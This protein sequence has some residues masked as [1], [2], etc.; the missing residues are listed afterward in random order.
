[1]IKKPIVL[2]MGEP[3]GIGSEIAIKSWLV[4]KQ[5][6]LPCFFLLDDYNKIS[7]INKKFKLN[8]KLKKISCPEEAVNYFKD[9]LPVL[10]M[11]INLSFNLGKPNPKNSKYVLKSI[12][13]SFDFFTKKKISGLVTLPVCKKTL[14]KNGFNFF[15]QTEYLSNLVTKRRKK[16]K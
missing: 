10:D 8:A 4:R 16:K 9:F 2:T 15:G 12:N 5:L 13:D 7:F 6:Q 14:K 3:S 11:E 1:M